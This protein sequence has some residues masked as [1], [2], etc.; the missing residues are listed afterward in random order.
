MDE[1]IGRKFSPLNV[2]ASF[3]TTSDPISKRRAQAYSAHQ[4]GLETSLVAFLI[5]GWWFFI[6]GWKYRPEIFTL[7]CFCFFLNHWQW[8]HQQ[9]EGTGVFS[10]S[11]LSKTNPPRFSNCRWKWWYRGVK[12]L[13]EFFALMRLWRCSLVLLVVLYNQSCLGIS[14]FLGWPWVY[15]AGLLA[16]PSHVPKPRAQVLGYKTPLFL[17][18]WQR[19]PWCFWR[20]FHSTH[21]RPLAVCPFSKRLAV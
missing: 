12:K 4:T 18:I 5:L 21:A 14:W 8:P 11:N 16:I 7:E 2:S 20:W 13:A 3:S 15:L 9:T 19:V 17:A 10:A 6:D 1:N